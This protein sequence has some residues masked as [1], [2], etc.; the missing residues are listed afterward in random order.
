MT[1][2][3]YDKYCVVLDDRGYIVILTTHKGIA[4]NV[5]KKHLNKDEK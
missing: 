5:I 1:L 4:L 3:E 2:V